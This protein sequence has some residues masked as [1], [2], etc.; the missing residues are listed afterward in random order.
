MT[1]AG[2]LVSPRIVDSMIL[3]S[4]DDIKS[5]VQGSSI[6]LI[7]LFC[8]YSSTAVLRYVLY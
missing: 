6:E 7:R 4:I 8:G 1:A 5:F 2:G 3:Y